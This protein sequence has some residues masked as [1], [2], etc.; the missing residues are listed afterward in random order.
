MPF[1]PYHNHHTPQYLSK[2]FIETAEGLRF[3]VV[4]N[5]L[6]EGK[7]LCFLR[8]V[9]RQQSWQKVGTCEAN[10]WLA[11]TAPHYLYTSQRLNAALH[12]VDCSKITQHYSARVGLQNLLAKA[13]TDAV[14][15]DL[16]ALCQLLKTAEL[17][18]SEVGVTGSLLLGTHTATSDI[19]LVFYNR[20][21]FQHTRKH[22]AHWITDAKLH[23]LQEVDWKL[24]YAR[25][26]CELSFA[27]YCWHEQRKYNKALI[28]QRKFDISWVSIT[29]ETDETY[30]KQGRVQL[31]AQVTDDTQGFD[32]PA[33]FY[34]QHPTIQSVVCFT[35]TYNGQAQNG[36]WVEICGQLEKAAH[37][38]QRIIVGSTREAKGEYLKVLLNETP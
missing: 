20:E 21:L 22:I 3:A 33:I 17:D 37:G 30:Q 25:R 36:E 10:Q 31:I 14:T 29:P 38:Q 2:D 7:V 34:I 12:A 27:Q 6:E 28:N 19:D 5:Q 26:E 18:L 35:A 11:K 4:Q 13:A 9:F 23:A 24:A 1:T 8:Y 32:Y 16:H 15:A